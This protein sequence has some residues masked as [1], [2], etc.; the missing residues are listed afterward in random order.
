MGDIRRVWGG[1]GVDG[2]V[3]GEGFRF[4]DFLRAFYTLEAAQME[5]QDKSEYSRMGVVWRRSQRSRARNAGVQVNP[6]RSTATRDS[7]AFP[8]GFVGREKTW[9]MEEMG[10]LG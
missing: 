4:H 2:V 3:G 6:W 1:V 10:R 5:I 7:S 9:W 8:L